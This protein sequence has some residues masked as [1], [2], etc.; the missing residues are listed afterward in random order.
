MCGGR[1]RKK[2]V[3]V[4]LMSYRLAGACWV[5]TALACALSGNRAVREGETVAERGSRGTGSF[6][7]AGGGTTRR[8]LWQEARSSRLHPGVAAG[9]EIAPERIDTRAEVRGRG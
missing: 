2:A 7:A 9:R 3:K 5:S 8:R 1:V 4:L 6:A